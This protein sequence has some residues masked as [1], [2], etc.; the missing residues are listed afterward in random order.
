MP[1][2][3]ITIIPGLLIIMAIPIH[4]TIP[5]TTTTIILTLISFEVTSSI[6]FPAGHPRLQH[7]GVASAP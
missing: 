1:S 4:L 3:H 6:S 7:L 5:M 2:H